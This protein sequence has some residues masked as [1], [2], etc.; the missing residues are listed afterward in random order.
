MV[1]PKEATALVQQVKDLLL[2]KKAENVVALDLRAVSQSLDYF[3]LATATSTP[4]LQA[5]ERHLVEKLEEEHLR[6]RP[7][8]GQSPRWVVLD[9]G[10]VVVH[11]MTREAR[12]FYDLEGFWADAA[13]L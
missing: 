2:E 11:L 10:E 5:L 6:P 1:K 7:T 12:E 13:R 9:Y 4:H 3:V 8:E